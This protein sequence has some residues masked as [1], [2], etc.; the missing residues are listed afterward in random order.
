MLGGRAERRV[1]PHRNTFDDT[2]VSGEKDLH[3]E[4]KFDFRDGVSG[5]LGGRTGRKR[6]RRRPAPLPFPPCRCASSTSTTVRAIRNTGASSTASAASRRGADGR[7]TRCRTARFPR[8]ERKRSSKNGRRPD[9][10]PTFPTS[11]SCVRRGCSAGFRSCTSTR[12]GA[13]PGSGGSSSWRT[14]TRPPPG[15][16]SRNS[17]PESRRRSRPSPTACRTRGPGNGSRC[18]ARCAS[19][20]GA[21][22]SS[23]SAGAAK[24]PKR[25]RPAWR[26]GR[27]RFRTGARS[28]G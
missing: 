28:S 3:L 6:R 1:R 14:T 19:R 4:Q 10:S 22:F 18:S 24:R 7:W 16:R 12:P 26:R 5:I 11:T 27:P 2:S 20:R 25:G 17:P 9:A 21:R 15:R 13:R 23:S 8:P